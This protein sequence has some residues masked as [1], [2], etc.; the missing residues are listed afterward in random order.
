MRDVAHPVPIGPVTLLH[1]RDFSLFARYADL[2]IGQLSLVPSSPRA[3]L[4]AS[5]KIFVAFL[6]AFESLASHKRAF[7][8]SLVVVM[9]MK[10][11]R[12]IG[13]PRG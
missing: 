9:C 6:A 5:G 10:L 13:H 4:P 11:S 12:P 2:L 7:L 3:L 8:F 1:G